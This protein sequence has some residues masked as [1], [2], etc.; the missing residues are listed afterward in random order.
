MQLYVPRRHRR[1]LLFPPGLLAL[2]G[3]LWLGCL[4][5]NTHPERLKQ[6][7]V[8]QIVM[9]PLVPSKM[10]WV[11]YVLQ[12]A[13]RKIE[14]FRSWQDAHFTGDAEAD[15]PQQARVAE[16]IR[17]IMADSGHSNGVRIHFAPA[18]R[19]KQL[20]FVLDLM[21][22]ENVKNYW[23][24]IRRTP[25]TLYAYTEVRHRLKP[26]EALGFT[27]CAG[28]GYY[29]NHAL[30]IQI[31]FEEWAANFQSLA[32]LQPLLQPEWRASAWLLAAITTLS[33]WQII[34]A[35]RMA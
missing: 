28:G 20:V 26:G 33:C 35:G 6:K 23:L 3:L 22:R 5:L 7:F 21:V 14:A 9:P 29:R 11:P 25:A 34:R 19:Y 16:D 18:S 30:P 4:V 32:W 13:P 2:A 1:K 15:A 8:I 12:L 24:D 31:S 17:A 10:S 27:S